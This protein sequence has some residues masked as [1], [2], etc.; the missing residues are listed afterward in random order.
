[1]LLLKR[2]LYGQK[3][4]GRVWNEYLHDGLININFVQSQFEE[5]VYYQNGTVFLVY[6]D[7]G[8]LARPS[9]EHIDALIK[10]MQEASCNTMT[11]EGDIM[12]CLG[13]NVTKLEDGCIKMSQPQLIEQIIKDINFKRNTK[14]QSTPA[15]SITILNRDRTGQPHNASWHFCLVIGKLNYLEKCSR[16]KI[17]YS[18]HQCAR[19]CEE[20]MVSHMDAVHCIV[21]YP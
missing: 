15:Q 8:I 2:N 20:P 10:E 3:Q 6:V 1:V 7:D 11:N 4:A 18:V 12:D 17:A 9:A 21:R 14:P 19:F 5:C 13:V 16:G